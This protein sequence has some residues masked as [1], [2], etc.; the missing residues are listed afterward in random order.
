MDVPIYFAEEVDSVIC[1]TQRLIDTG[2]KP[3]FAVRANKMTEAQG[4]FGKKWHS[5]SKDNLHLALA[6]PNTPY[7]SYRGFSVRSGIEVCKILNETIKEVN[8]QVK[9]PNDIY[10]N[11]KKVF[12]SQS[13]CNVENNEATKN[14][15]AVGLNVNTKQKAFPNKYKDIA[16]SLRIESNKKQE[17]PLIAEKVVEG[18]L[19]AHAENSSMQED[20]DKL[21]YLKNKNILHPIEGI[22]LGINSIGELQIESKEDKSIHT[23]T[24]GDI[25]LDSEKSLAEI[26]DKTGCNFYI[27]F[28]DITSVSRHRSSI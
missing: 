16:T 26:L 15:V 3:P 19:K 22:S 17:I 7:D 21:D 27:N 9:W 14:I 25:I 12:G 2:L 8:F 18:L 13:H 11:G 20:Y 10:C 4:R 23:I 5:E 28:G 1:E 6:L 24:T